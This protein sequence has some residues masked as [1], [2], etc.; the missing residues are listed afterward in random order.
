[1]AL[2]KTPQATH[3]TAQVQTEKPVVTSVGSFE[4]MDETV[5]SKPAAND[6]APVA[7]APAQEAVAVPTALVVRPIA[8][9]AVAAPSKS[10]G[11]AFKREVEEIRGAV[12]MS[13]GN[14]KV[15]KGN[16]GEIM[17]SGGTKLGRWVKVM[18]IGWDDH[19]EIS[20]GSKAAAS[21]DAVGYSKDGITMDSTLGRDYSNWVGHK[22]DD[23]VSFLK[24]GDW[25]EAKKSRFIDIA[26]IVYEC[27]SGDVA[28]GTRI[29]VTLSPSSISSFEAYQNDLLATAIGVSRGFPGLTLP[30]DPFIFHFLRDVTT[31]GDNT[32]T[33]LKVLSTLP[34]KY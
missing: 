26:C 5:S 17:E 12:D 31:K 28:Q 20:P 4:S 32:W 30:E 18:M 13:Y 19:T 6:S 11:A 1:M 23:Y 10:E 3:T 33:K 8:A 7:A 2:T 22:V 34:A 9:V 25:P 14:F 24:S 27:D 21:K 15:F 16:N 29:Q